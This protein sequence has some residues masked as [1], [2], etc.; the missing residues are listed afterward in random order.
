M[1]HP[2]SAI[3]PAPQPPDEQLIAL[4][5]AALKQFGRGIRCTLRVSGVSAVLIFPDD[6]PKPNTQEPPK[7]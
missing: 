2:M 5:G 7:C 1:D 4:V 6:K 3:A